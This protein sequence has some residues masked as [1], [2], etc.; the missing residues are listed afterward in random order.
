M[1]YFKV[2]ISDRLTSSKC[3][4]LLWRTL[5]TQMVPSDEEWRFGLLDLHSKCQSAA[6]RFLDY[7]IM[8]SAGKIS[9]MDIPWPGFLSLHHSSECLLFTHIWNS[10]WPSFILLSGW[11]DKE[12]ACG[13][14]ISI[15]SIMQEKVSLRVAVWRGG[16]QFLTGEWGEVSIFLSYWRLYSH[17][18]L[19]VVLINLHVSDGSEFTHSGK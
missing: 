6:Y 17:S 15:S 7:T 2:C 3:I 8:V 4:I 19:S 11:L 1:V 5:Y 18:H 13:K 12:Q 14:P 16:L 10:L 9:R